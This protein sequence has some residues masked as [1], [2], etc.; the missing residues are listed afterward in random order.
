MSIQVIGAVLDCD[1]EDLSPARRMVLVVLANYVG[2]EDDEAWP[3]QATI[4]RQ[5]GCKER[6]IRDHLK[7]LEA[8]GYLSR[9]TSH[10]GAGNGSRTKYKLHVERLRMPANNGPAK[11]AGANEPAKNVISTGS[12]LPL[13]NRQEP[14]KTKQP[15]RAKKS[16]LGDWTP[17]PS[18]AQYAKDKGLTHEQTKA[19]WEKFSDHHRQHGN[20]FQDWDAAWRNWVRRSL[21]YA[22]QRKPVHQPQEARSL[23]EDAVHRALRELE[24]EERE[25]QAGQEL[26]HAQMDQAPQ[27]DLGGHG[28]TLE[29]FEGG[30]A[31]INQG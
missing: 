26:H 14:P 31:A 21:E 20:K 7:W 3:R 10:L 25:E 16:Q 28:A 23:T 8:Q 5:A 2:N 4:A 22:S 17:G 12:E 6:N 24:L 19:E 1:H 13:N 30:Q 11:S 27:S 18:G 15:A 9:R 29:L